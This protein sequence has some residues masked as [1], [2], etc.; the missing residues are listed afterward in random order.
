MDY[1]SCLAFFVILLIVK[2]F[3]ERYTLI[4]T[5][6]I[7]IGTILGDQLKVALAGPITETISGITRHYARAS[8]AKPLENL[9]IYWINM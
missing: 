6:M 4:V 9:S 8:L 2:R 1:N 5:A 3:K 7:V